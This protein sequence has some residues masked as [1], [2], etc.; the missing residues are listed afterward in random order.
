MNKKFI[1]ERFCF[2]AWE[3]MDSFYL[4]EGADQY[5]RNILLDD[6]KAVLRIIEV[7]KVY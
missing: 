2:T 1:V 6:R 4:E 3:E 7:H 5:C